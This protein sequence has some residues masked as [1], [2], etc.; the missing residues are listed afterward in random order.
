MINTP[1]CQR[2]VDFLEQIT[3]IL[4][5][6]AAK[7]GPGRVGSSPKFSEQIQMRERIRPLP[8]LSKT[9]ILDTARL[10]EPSPIDIAPPK[11]DAVVQNL[12]T[13]EARRHKTS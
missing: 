4:T 6:T 7:N 2:S 1:A 10:T 8:N 13:P 12:H 11:V 3:R 5:A 9:Y